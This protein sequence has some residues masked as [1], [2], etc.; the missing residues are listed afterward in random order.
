MC[1]VAGWRFARSEATRPISEE[2]MLTARTPVPNPGSSPP[3]KRGAWDCVCP[4]PSMSSDVVVNK[5]AGQ[6]GHAHSQQ[7]GT[8]ASWECPDGRVSLGLE[9]KGRRRWKRTGLAPKRICRQ[10]N[11]G[12]HAGMSENLTLPRLTVEDFGGAA[13]GCSIPPRPGEGASALSVGNFAVASYRHL[14]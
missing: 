1:A 13:P 6:R 9:G 10:R 7:L 4:I 12:R 2:I 14:R 5:N 11:N 3:K 8:A